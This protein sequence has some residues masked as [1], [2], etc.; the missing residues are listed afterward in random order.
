MS[1]KKYSERHE[2]LMRR[3]T[4]RPE[5]SYADYTKA[6]IRRRGSLK[7]RES[8][9]GNKCELF[10]ER[11]ATFLTFLGFRFGEDAR[12]QRMMQRNRGEET[13]GHDTHPIG[14][15][16]YA[17]LFTLG[18]DQ[19]K[20]LQFWEKQPAHL[21]PR[22][23]TDINLSNC[24]YCF[25]KGPRALG[26]IRNAK[27]EFEKTLPASLQAE[28]RKTG[29]PNSINWWIRLEDTRKRTANKKSSEGGTIRT[30][31]MFG[32]KDMDY[33]KIKAQAI[34]E[35]RKGRRTLSNGLPAATLNCECTD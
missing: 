8:V 28:C 15:F 19:A 24:V 3:P 20:V 5:Q 26:K 11:P 23:P 17:P 7:L 18:I 25:L 4:F 12:Y 16:S 35:K 21:R 9:L 34:R 30:F 13:P 31:G 6:S 22:L 14:E 1:I 10:G 29:T 32:L 2:F 33:R 27:K